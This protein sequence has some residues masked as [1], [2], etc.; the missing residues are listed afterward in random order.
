VIAPVW[1][2][3]VVLKAGKEDPGAGIGANLY[4][5]KPY[6]YYKYVGHELSL[7]AAVSGEDYGASAHS[8]FG[9]P[10]ITIP[11]KQTGIDLN[12]MVPHALRSSINLKTTI[13][14]PDITQTKVVWTGAHVAVGTSAQNALKLAAKAAA[15]AA[16]EETAFLQANMKSWERSYVQS[17][18]SGVGFVV[19]IG[20]ARCCRRFNPS[21][22]A[23]SG[24]CMSNWAALLPAVAET[25]Q[26]YP[27]ELVQ[28]TR[29]TQRVI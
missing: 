17:K 9:I 1:G 3:S 18:A 28:G 5:Y 15:K 25:E 11:N 23:N 22:H 12:W 7:G 10:P 2:F 27:L 19:E 21:G 8:I 29:L 6:T 14:Y 20:Y 26:F 16:G 4:F 24:H 13:G